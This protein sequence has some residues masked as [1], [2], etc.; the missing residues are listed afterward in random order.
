[1]F[2]ITPGEF[3]ADVKVGAIPEAVEV[4]GQVGGAAV[5]S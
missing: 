5:G 4:I 1:V 3:F 2:R